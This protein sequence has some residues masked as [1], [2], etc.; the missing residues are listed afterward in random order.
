MAIRSQKQEGGGPGATV[1]YAE[2][3]TRA[4]K[5]LLDAQ[6]MTYA[7]L[8]ERL[9]GMGIRETEASISQKVRRGTFQFSFFF[10]CLDA[11]HVPEVLVKAPSVALTSPLQI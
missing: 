8:A 5:R 9:S 1:D 2:C 7:D 6:G 3:A 10:Q 4:L 11:L